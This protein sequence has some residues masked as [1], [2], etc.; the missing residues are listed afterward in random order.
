MDPLRISMVGLSRWESVFVQTSVDLASGMEIPP[1]R[2]VE[3]PKGADVLL[4]D[5]DH[6]RY[7]SLDDGDDK[8][9]VVSFSEDRD[10]STAGR[11]LQRPIGYADLI[12]MLKD[13]E[14]ELNKPT[15]VT[16]ATQPAPP[17]RESEPARPRDTLPTLTDTL[18]GQPEPPATG[19]L[20][21]ETDRGVESLSDKA[22]P[23]RRFVEATRLLG[24][25]NRILR[26]GIPAEVTHPKYPSLVIIPNH[27]AFA[28]SSDALKIPGMF[29]DS[30]MSFA[31]RDL[32]EDVADAVLSSG[33]LQPLSH[34]V[35]CAALFGSE[36]RLTLNS[37]PQ[38][39]LALIGTPDFDTVPNLP[40]H[41]RIAKYMISHVASLGDIARATDVSISLVIDFCNACEAAG[42]VRRIPDGIPK[43][44]IDEHGVLQLFGRVRDLFK[45][46]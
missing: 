28:A 9:V 18:G 36:G 38:D 20:F 43:Q 12:A 14:N 11:G 23:A 4:V 32:P 16:R 10:L 41:K 42:L 24:I 2:F 17:P 34:L 7:V 33:K 40:E 1:C 6:R 26:W 35:Y 25:L 27:N 8:P 22:R 45:D 30:A 13:I 5:A 31:I 39:R 3:D 19:V 21:D 15:A 37:N 29:R 46:T 44:A